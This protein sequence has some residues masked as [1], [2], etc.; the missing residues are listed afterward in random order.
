MT[1]ELKP[2][3]FCD[4]N[5]LDVFYGNM[6]SNIHCKKCACRLVFDSGILREDIEKAWNTRPGLCE[7]CERLDKYVSTKIDENHYKCGAWMAERIR[8]SINNLRII[9]TP[10]QN[11]FILMALANIDEIVE[12]LHIQESKK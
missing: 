1:E 8:K 3:P 2:C 6:Y 4:S 5:E 9:G 12:E 11:K 7:R 10:E